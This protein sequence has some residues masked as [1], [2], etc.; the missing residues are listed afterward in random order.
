MTAAAGPRAEAG[1]DGVDFHLHSTC[2]DGVLAPRAVVEL[3]AGAGIRLCSLT[4]HDTLAGI[5]EATAAAA[6]CGIAF[7]AGVELSARWQ[8]RTI[9]VVGLGIDPEAASIVAAVRSRADARHL[10]AE[11]IRDRL[12]RAGAPGTAAYAIVA[13]HP[14]PTR[15]H[16]A[17][18]LVALGA[19]PDPG[20]AFERWLGRGKPAQVPSEWP[21]VTEAV[22]AIVAAGGAAVL[23]HPLR[24]T[25]SNG[26]RRELCRAFRD[27]GGTALEV[28]TG[29]QAP[30]QLELATGLALRSGLEGSVGSD[31]HDPALPWHRPGRLAKLPAAVVPVWRRWH[32]LP[33]AAARPGTR[34]PPSFRPAEA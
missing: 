11:R 15:T 12:D 30:H 22:A 5:P 24:Y 4:D 25:L 10:R 14:L 9:H 16:F 7:V 33:G 28:A 23:A 21:D 26:Q 27:C 18:A 13:E 1:G 6:E 29:G 3:A 31:C 32:D 34:D 20:K 2:S 19:A 8:G 17:R